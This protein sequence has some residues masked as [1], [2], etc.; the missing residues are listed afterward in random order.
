M[1]DGAVDGFRLEKVTMLLAQ[2]TKPVMTCSP[3][4]TGATKVAL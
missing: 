4:Q 1:L 3:A 2:H